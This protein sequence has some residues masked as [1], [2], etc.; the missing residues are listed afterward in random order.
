MAIAAH[1]SILESEAA[2]DKWFSTY[3]G[4]KDWQRRVERQ[5]MTERCVYNKFGF[6]RYYFDRIEGL[7][8]EALAWIPQS[9]VAI[10][11]DKGIVNVDE[12]LREL[13]CEPLLQVHDSGVFQYPLD[14]EAECLE[15]IREQMQIIVPYDDPLII[16]VGA[17]VSDKS[18]G[19]CV[20][21]DFERKMLAG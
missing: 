18:W 12:N 10:I 13:R 11:I 4:I 15:K 1:C 20:D 9:T 21:W 2:Q 8:P 5:L 6:R 7:L 3:P 14:N 19:D 17:K 16:P